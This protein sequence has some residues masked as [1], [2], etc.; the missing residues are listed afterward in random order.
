MPDAL[1]GTRD[2]RVWLIDR[3]DYWRRPFAR[4]LKNAGLEV[5]ATDGYTLP[6]SRLR[7]RL[8]SPDLVVLACTAVTAA[9]LELVEVARRQHLDVL[10]LAASLPA[11]V[12][13]EL[14]LAGAFDVTRMPVQAT[15]FVDLVQ[16]TLTEAASAREHR[17]AALVGL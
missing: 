17:A 7:A 11:E 12:M 16:Q 15:E 2:R 3:R 10:V 13:R 1:R 9:E 14:F 6:P 5:C 8:R 4:A